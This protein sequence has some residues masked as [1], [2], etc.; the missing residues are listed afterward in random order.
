MA[1]ELERL[2]DGSAAAG[3][4]VWLIDFGGFGL[5]RAH[6][7]QQRD[8]AAQRRAAQSSAEQR[9]AAQSMA[10]HGMAWRGRH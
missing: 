8:R 2:F 5:R 6:R 4:F 1:L 10:R 3:R 9:R 7:A